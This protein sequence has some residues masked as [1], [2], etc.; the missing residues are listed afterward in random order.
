M[1]QV[2]KK[3]RCLQKKEEKNLC[4]KMSQNILADGYRVLCVNSRTLITLVP[5]KM[6]VRS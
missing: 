1:Y 3:T 6:N 4:I 5:N 2:K